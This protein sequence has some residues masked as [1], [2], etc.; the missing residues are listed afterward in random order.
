MKSLKQRIEKRLQFIYGNQIPAEFA[1]EITRMVL[2]EKGT[3]VF[4]PQLW[5]EKDVAL[6]TYGDTFYNDCEMPLEVLN[7]FT[8]EFIK[9]AFSIIHILPFFPY[10]SDDGFSVIDFKKVNPALGEWEHINRLGKK[11]RLMVDLVINH[12]SSKGEWFQNFLKGQGIGSDFFIEASPDAD[13]SAVTRPRNT[14]LLTPFKTANGVKHVWTTFSADQIDLNFANPEVLKTFIDILLFYLNNGTQVIRLDAIAF[15]W[16]EQGTSC[17]H[18]HKTHEVVKLLRDIVDVSHPGTIIITETNVPNTENLSYFGNNDEAHM[19]YQFSLPPLLLHALFSGNGQYLTQ[20]AK[21]IPDTGN[22]QTFFNFTASHDGIGVRPLKGLLPESEKKPLY[23]AIKANGGQVS[24]KSN[25]DGTESPYELNITYFDSLMR[26]KNGKD[27]F[28]LE[29]FICS[30]TIALTLKGVTAIYIHSLLATKNYSEGVLKTGRART[31][32]RP[33]LNYFKLRSDLN[34]ET[35]R[36][37]AYNALI[38]II[39]V[40]KKQSA[41]HPAAKQEILDFGPDFFSVLRTDELGNRL[42]SVSNLT[43][44]E[45][46]LKITDAELVNLY[47]D[48]ITNLQLNTSSIVFKPYQTFWLT[49]FTD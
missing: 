27:N 49:Q 21:T 12:A 35:L 9:D 36:S 45:K 19:V 16:K 30:Q 5:S 18:H 4:N 25:T 23:E 13:L 26:T 11:Y 6:I 46:Q 14:P 28:Q 2:S 43:A 39:E 1:G 3:S 41:F 33:Q 37:I 42:L 10:S 44:L 47:Y 17:L 20:W 38:R 34:H 8:D 7:S 48:Q 15:L 31:I 24:M 29:R 40:R 32:N 22:Q